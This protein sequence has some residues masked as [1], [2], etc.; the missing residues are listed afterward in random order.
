MKKRMRRMMRMRRRIL[1]LRPRVALV[2]YT[3]PK[4]HI[5]RVSLCIVCP[6]AGHCAVF[7]LGRSAAG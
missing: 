5:G 2:V 6:G 3:V 7:V 1:A 4:E